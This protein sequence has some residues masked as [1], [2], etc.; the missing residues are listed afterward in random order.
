MITTEPIPIGRLWIVGITFLHQ[1][2][3]LVDPG[4]VRVLLHQHFILLVNQAL[5][6]ALLQVADQYLLLLLIVH[7]TKLP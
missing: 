7:L 6:L 5:E 2:V 4:L 1:L 3:L